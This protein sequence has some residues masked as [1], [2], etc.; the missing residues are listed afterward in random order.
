VTATGWLTLSQLNGLL[1]GVIERWNDEQ[2]EFLVVAEV[3]EVRRGPTGH[4]YLKL[5]ERSAEGIVAALDAVIWVGAARTVEE[6]RQ[7]TGTALSAGMQVLFRGRV[8]FHERFGLKLDIRGIDP[9]YTLGEMQRQRREVIARLEQEGLLDQNKRLPFPLVPQRIAIVASTESAGF[10]DFVDQLERNPFAYRFAYHV[11][12]ALTQGDGAEASIAQ[13]LARVSAMARQFDVAVVIRGGGSQVDLSCFDTYGVGAAIARCAVPVIT[14]IGHERDET[15]ADMVAHT[16]AKTP[17]AAAEVIVSA[18]RR[19]EERVEEAAA[20]LAIEA[21]DI[22][23]VAVPRLAELSGR[24]EIA[25]RRATAEERERLSAAM[26][27]LAARTLSGLRT[28][29]LSLDTMVRRMWQASASLIAGVGARL[30]GLQVRLRIRARAVSAAEEMVLEAY[31]R[32]LTNLDPQRVLARGFSITRYLGR[33]VR[34]AG[35]VPCAAV[36]ET[37]LAKGRLISKVESRESVS[38]EGSS[39]VRQSDGAPRTDR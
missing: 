16:R 23:H 18:V 15:V 21:Q 11:F 6:F 38:E 29:G 36:V 2:G 13:A 37:T 10:Q 25:A 20:Q 31:L 24:F 9:T 34:D 35:E 4:Y 32:H 8:T 39:D 1:R 5:V 22:L 19:Y 26:A 30:D 33:V 17:T 14:G 3:S 27:A 12:P 7:V 28:H